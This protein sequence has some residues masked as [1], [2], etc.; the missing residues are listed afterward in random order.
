MHVPVLYL[1]FIW[2]RRRNTDQER[3]TM[4]DGNL[5]F[6]GQIMWRKGEN[7]L[8]WSVPTADAT[9]GR[10]I[11]SIRKAVFKN[12]DPTTNDQCQRQLYL[13]T[14]HEQRWAQFQIV[15]H[16]IMDRLWPALIDAFGYPV[17]E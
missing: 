13:F 3:R 15:E 14:L 12:G 6:N 9:T 7:A 1:P 17:M 16:V 11:M 4:E 5:R 2:L 10:R 8:Q